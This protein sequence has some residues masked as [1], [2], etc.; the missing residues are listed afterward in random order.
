[1][2]RPTTVAAVTAGERAEHASPRKGHLGSPEVGA[3]SWTRVDHRAADG[4]P[5]DGWPRSTI[6]P[7][8]LAQA[9]RSEQIGK[10][11]LPPNGRPRFHDA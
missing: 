9:T 10:V 1:M 6:Q 8:A 2:D 3:S 11:A 4:R 5:S 7:R